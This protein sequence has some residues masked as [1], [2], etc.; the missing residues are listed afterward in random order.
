VVNLNLLVVVRGVAFLLALVHLLVPTQVGNDG[1]VSSAPFHITC[2]CYE[3][4][5]TGSLWF[6]GSG[7]LRLTLLASVAIHVCLQ[8]R[9]T[10]KALVADLALVLLLRVG[11]HLRA[12]LA[13]H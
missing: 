9:R 1:E 6:C 11:R 12:E 5:S 2:K 8:R 4:V 13:H 7:G 3:H 10:S